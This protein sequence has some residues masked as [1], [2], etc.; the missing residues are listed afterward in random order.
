MDLNPEEQVEA[1]VAPPVIEETESASPTSVEVEAV[2]PSAP[3]PNPIKVD[4]LRRLKALENRGHPSGRAA[5]SVE[6][7]L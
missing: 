3:P 6:H 5:R 4:A 7:S 2:E 1:E